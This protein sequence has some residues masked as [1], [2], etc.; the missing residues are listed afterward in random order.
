V[1]YK[2]LK[3]HTSK[4]DAKQKTETIFVDE[5][6]VKR[7]SGSFYWDYK[8]FN[9]LVL[10]SIVNANYEFL[11]CDIRTNGRVLDGGVVE[12]TKFYE[13]LKHEELDLPLPRKPDNST[14]DLPYVFVGDETFALCKDLLKPFS[15]KQLT[16]EC[17]V[18]NYCLSQAWR[19]TENTFGIT[20][21]RFRVF[22]TEINLKL[23]NS[24]LVLLCS[25]Q[26]FCV[27]HAIRTPWT[28]DES[29][30][31]QSDI[32]TP[33]QC[34]HNRH[35]GEESRAVREKFCRYFNEEGKIPW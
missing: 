15:E 29:E 11:Y 17:R 16:N 10:M 30:E 19:V 3:Q 23:K 28:P 4:S 12:N 21:S 27:A 6:H 14:S 13:E 34:G 35:A 9:S 26:L 33:L 22:H 18:S 8:G 20:A 1:A 2:Y 25:T 31:E 5:K 32:L 7:R 24:C